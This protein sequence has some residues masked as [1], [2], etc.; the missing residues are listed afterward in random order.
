MKPVRAQRDF[1]TT[2]KVI[3]MTAITKA[4]RNELF[5]KGIAFGGLFG[6]MVGSLIALQ[7]GN[8]RVEHARASVWRR[9]RRPKSPD[10]SKIFV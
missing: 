2:E 3:S 8:P 6:L 4:F 5:L 10:Y 1:T 9:V 7:M